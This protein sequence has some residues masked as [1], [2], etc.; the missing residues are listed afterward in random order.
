MF[1]AI[2]LMVTLLALL[3]RRFGGLNL[4]PAGVAIYLLI[5][6]AVFALMDADNPFTTAYIAWPFLGGVAGMGILLF[7]RKPFWRSILLAACALFILTLLVPQLWLATYTRE[8]AWIPALA[9]CIPMGLFA[10]QV[11]AIFGWPHGILKTD[12]GR[13]HRK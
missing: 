7:T 13:V 12:Q 5:W 2:T 3:S 8:D 11:D 1:V 9:A 6:I 4:L 10:P